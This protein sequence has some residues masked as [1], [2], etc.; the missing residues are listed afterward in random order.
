[1]I[2]LL[3]GGL[4]ISGC[5]GSHNTLKTEQVDTS[6]TESLDEQPINPD[7]GTLDNIP[8]SDELPQ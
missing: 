8:V 2:A 6:M 3:I 7:I 5:S 1:M 4:F